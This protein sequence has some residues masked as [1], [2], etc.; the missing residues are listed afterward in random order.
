MA[1]VGHFRLWAAGA[2][3]E[4]NEVVG[5]KVRPENFVNDGVG[6]LGCDVNE[7]LVVLVMA[8]VVKEVEVRSMSVHAF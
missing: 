3:V 8:N 5:R 6:V 1:L 7:I 4:I 2:G